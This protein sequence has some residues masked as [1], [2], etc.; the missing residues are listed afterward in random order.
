M[1]FVPI[2]FV[3]KKGLCLRIKT[4]LRMD[5]IVPIQSVLVDIEKRTYLVMYSFLI[6]PDEFLILLLPVVMCIV[7]NY[8]FLLL[9]FIVFEVIDILG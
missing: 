7:F 8:S 6:V 3:V 2:I 9:G 1:T 5:I 4:C